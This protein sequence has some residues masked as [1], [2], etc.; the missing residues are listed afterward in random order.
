M[1]IEQI[2]IYDSIE[3][4]LERIP[5][6]KVRK[7]EY[8]VK[9]DVDNKVNTY[10]VLNGNVRIVNNV[11]C[12][13]IQIDENGEDWFTGNL[14][15]V[16]NQYLNCDI[17]ATEETTLL[18]IAEEIFEELLN[19]VEFA[20]IFYYKMSQRIYQMYKRMLI[21]NMY[22]QKEILASHIIEHAKNDRFVCPNMNALCEKLGF[23]RRN[24]YNSLNS[25]IDEG[26]LERRGN[27]ILIC[28]REALMEQGRYALEHLA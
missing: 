21:N 7:G 18:E 12:K 19:D 5:I 13:K 25:F 24:L 4:Y 17:I 11:G 26:I 8:I 2:A 9:H 20:K 6:V 1:K 10:Y 22:N 14:S 23:S 3:R 28:N 16:Y 27:Y 15:K